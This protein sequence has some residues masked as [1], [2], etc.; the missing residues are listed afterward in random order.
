MIKF[1]VHRFPNKSYS[2]RRNPTNNNR[3]DLIFSVQVS[4]FNIDDIIFGFH[5]FLVLLRNVDKIFLVREKV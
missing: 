4:Q 5:V 1:T 3:R 2:Y